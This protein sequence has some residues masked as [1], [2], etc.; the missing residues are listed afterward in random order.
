[1]S[2]T[3][4]SSHLNSKELKLQKYLPTLQF[5][6]ELNPRVSNFSHKGNRISIKKKLVKIL[7]YGYD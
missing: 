1:M 7:Y 6:Q 3:A 2:L 4:N 5:I